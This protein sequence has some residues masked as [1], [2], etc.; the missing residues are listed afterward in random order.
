M[1]T[2]LHE[3]GMCPETEGMVVPKAP[4]PILIVTLRY[5]YFFDLVQAKLIFNLCKAAL[6]VFL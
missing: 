2:A 5:L 6:N 1:Y 4:I 3:S